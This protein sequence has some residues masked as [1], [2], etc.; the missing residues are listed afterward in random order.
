MLARD[1]LAGKGA[2]T[3]RTTAMC[4]RH[5]CI[6]AINGA[7]FDRSSG[8]PYSGITSVGEL[9]RSVTSPR[10]HV[11]IDS[12]LRFDETTP[13]V[14]LVA[15][16]PDVFNGGGGFE[17]QEHRFTLKGVNRSRGPDGLVAY[18]RRWAAFTPGTSGRELVLEALAIPTLTVGARR[19]F[20]VTSLRDTGGPIP[21]NGVVL[22][23]N[24][25]G[26]ALLADVWSRVEEGTLLSTVSL[27][28]APGPA[29]LVGTRPVILRNN[30]VIMDRSTFGRAKH[31]RSI[32][33]ARPDG[34]IL[35]VV[36]DGRASDRRG[37][38]LRQAAWLVRAL[39]AS[40]AAN[41][42]GGGSSTLAVEGRLHSRPA[43]TERSVATS[44]IVVRR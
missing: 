42:D 23:G 3:A 2:R 7:F 20:A 8:L 30:Q 4:R 27:E 40:D 10:P 37:M 25:E 38:S 32:L 18:T 33:A 15:T 36:I 29:T 22:S 43:G 35:L 44:L 6:A 9:I 14:Q 34:T 19:E 16:E 21:E 39:G 41:L 24:G 5:G 17:E 12:G 28:V 11:A 31:P 1:R 26:A 13:S